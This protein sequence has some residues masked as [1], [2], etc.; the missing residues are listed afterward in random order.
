[1]DDASIIELLNRRDEKGIEEIKQKYGNLCL[2][3]A[4][5]ILSQREDMEECVN[6]AYY[7]LWNNIPPER[8]NDLKSYLCCIVRRI[9]INRA[10]YNSAAKRDRRFTVS[11]S[12]IADCVPSTPDEDIA[13]SDLAD[14]ISR[15]L[16][17]QDKKHRVVFV[18]RYTYGD[19]VSDIS[20]CCAI[21][22]K[23][24]ATYLFRTRKKL[25]EFLKKEGYDYE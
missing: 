20:K 6:S 18:R 13:L 14:A 23:T 10:G 5:N 19:S 25:K 17:T 15:F 8:P 3:I 21:N 24:V 7:E 1:M 2:Y 4:G 11:L 16:R 22:E 9:A 12:E